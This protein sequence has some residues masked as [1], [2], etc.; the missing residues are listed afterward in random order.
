MDAG[1]AASSLIEASTTSPTNNVCVPSS[2]RWRTTQS[3]HATASS[4]T[5]APL[6]A[7]RTARPLSEV[8]SSTAG[9]ENFTNTRVSVASQRFTVNE[10]PSEISRC[11][12]ASLSMPTPISTGSIDSWVTQLA[13]IALRSSPARDP[14]NVRAFGIFHVTLFSSSSSMA[15]RIRLTFRS[16]G[17]RSSPLYALPGAARAPLSALPGAARAPLP[18]LAIGA[19]EAA[20]HVRDS[21]E[22]IGVA[23]VDHAHL[24]QR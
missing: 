4:N 17:G 8:P 2:R 19:E 18:A 21:D 1:R 23:G 10:P 6:D 24:G 7:A 5:G 14:I 13:V 16:A 15:M 3:I 9:F 20:G 12:T 11:V 22:A